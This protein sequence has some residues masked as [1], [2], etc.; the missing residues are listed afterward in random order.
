MQNCKV[1]KNCNTTCVVINFQLNIYWYKKNVNVAALVMITTCKLILI[2]IRKQSEINKIKT[3]TSTIKNKFTINTYK[4][5]KHFP[6][7]AYS[8]LD[9]VI[10]Q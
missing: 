3:K 9:T 6:L 7:N 8:T 4:Q 5:I 1:V 10:M 2:S